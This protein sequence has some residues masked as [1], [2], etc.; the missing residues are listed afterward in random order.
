MTYGRVRRHLTAPLFFLILT[1]L[2]ARPAPAADLS[3]TLLSA[4]PSALQ[5]RGADGAAF[6]VRVSPATW[7]LERGAVV[8]PPGL[9]PGETLRVR[10]RHVRAGDVALLV[11]DAGTAAALDA[12]RRRALSGTV[13][14]VDGAVWT[15]QP[16]GEDAPVPVLVSAR[17]VFRAGGAAGPGVRL[18]RRGIGPGDDAGPGERAT[19]GGVRL[20]RP[21][22]IGRPGGGRGRG[23]AGGPARLAL[24][25]RHRDTPGPRPA[26]TY[27]RGGRGA[28]SRRGRG[29][30]PE[31][32]GP[33]GFACGHRA[34]DARPGPPERGPGRGGQPPRRQRVR[35]RRPAREGEDEE[36]GRG[37]TFARRRGTLRVTA[38]EDRRRKKEPRCALAPC[39]WPAP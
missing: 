29:D 17:T 21:G 2:S 24:R 5:V 38:A 22:G 14:A 39:C 16:S 33:S 20:G 31:V 9:T 3:V 4:A 7:V 35:V 25:R 12:H 18:R 27:G 34:G 36:E 15:V 10:L 8:S 32:G 19:G 23:R 30:A 28:D 6:A 1:L 37:R 26:D 13:L 11:C